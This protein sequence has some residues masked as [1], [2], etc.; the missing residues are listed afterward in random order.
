MASGG[1]FFFTS[2]MIY[3]ESLEKIVSMMIEI[4]IM[5]RTLANMYRELPMFHALGFVYGS[6]FEPHGSP[7][8]S[9]AMLS[10]LHM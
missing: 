4:I 9:G 8:D 3:S 5:N 2:M 10:Q 1:V 6:S 7:Y